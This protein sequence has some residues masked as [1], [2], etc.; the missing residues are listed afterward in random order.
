VLH[1][2]EKHSRHQQGVD[3]VAAA[4]IQNH[5]PQN[6]KP[7]EGV[8]PQRLEL[9]QPLTEELGQPRLGAMNTEAPPQ[10]AELMGREIN[11]IRALALVGQ[12]S[13][14][15]PITADARL[16]GIAGER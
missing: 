6:L 9:V 4:F 14:I 10:F 13:W 7:G 15:G 11:R 3:P 8:G 12:G 5:R 1:L 16:Q 2:I